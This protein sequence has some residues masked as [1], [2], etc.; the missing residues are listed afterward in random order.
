MRVAER[1][2]RVAADQRQRVAAER[3]VP[4]VLELERGLVLPITPEQIHDL[5]ERT[6]P[7]F[8]T[9]EALEPLYQHPAVAEVAVIGVPDAKWGE[10]IKALVVL[11]P[12]AAATERD[13]IE[14]CR[15]RLAHYK[16]PTSIELRDALV[17]TAT[18]KLQKFKLRAPY[19][20]GRARQIN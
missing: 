3:V 6:F 1:P 16:C 18:G 11:R 8:L 4:D 14:H 7:L 2:H 15:S 10:T 17:R 5:A 20:D 12:G 13:L 9:T 19:W